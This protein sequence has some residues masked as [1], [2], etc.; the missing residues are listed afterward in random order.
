MGPSGCR[1]ALGQV[2]G[3]LGKVLGALDLVLLVMLMLTGI[4]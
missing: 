3:M 1:E 4:S 2:L